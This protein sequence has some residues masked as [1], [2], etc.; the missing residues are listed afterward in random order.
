MKTPL[1]TVYIVSHNYGDY[2]SDAIESV[3]RQTFD[4]WELLLIDDGSSDNT[5]DLMNLYKGEEKV[6]IFKTGG[7]GLPSVCNLALKKARGKYIIRLDGDDIFNENILLIL[8]NYLERH[9]ET[10]MVFPDYY[11]VDEFSEIYGE[12][13][14]A[15]LSKK[16]HLFDV[17]PNGACTLTRRDILE[18]IGGYREDL[19]A[20]DGYD[21]W[22]RISQEYKCAN[23]NL[24]LFYYRRHQ[25][26]MTHNARHILAAKRRI[27]MDSIVNGLLDFRPIIAVIPCRKNF[28]FCIDLWKQDMCGKT[29]LERRLEACVN[30]GILDYIVVASDNAEVED[31]IRLFDDKRIIFIARRKE[32]TIRSST[33]VPTL[34][35]IAERLD[36]SM[37]GVT[38]LSYIPTPFVTTGTLEESISTLVMNKAD[39]SMGVEELRDALYKRTS[40]GLQALNSPREL[41]VDFDMVYRETSTSLCTRNNNFKSGSLTGPMIINFIVSKEES[42]FI[43]SYTN[44]EVARRMFECRMN[45]QP[46]TNVREKP[47]LRQAK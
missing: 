40:H 25:N 36:P 35:K 23:V 26:N 39:C 4:S 43:N 28:D 15:K 19:G 37:H 18:R 16:N 5:S 12:E 31:T 22:S 8:V 42:F 20:Q 30:S 11:L 3:F 29:L 7:I 13:K 24:P 44:L 33:I 34:E 45:A 41:S 2:L 32:D 1:V 47:C 10:V 27:K 46:D 38:A 9:S 21:I 6:K 14:R 17:P